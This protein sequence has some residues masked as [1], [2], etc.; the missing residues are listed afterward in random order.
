LGWQGSGQL[1]DRERA[2]NRL[3]EHVRSHLDMA[4]L[5]QIIW[6]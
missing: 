3:A 5:Q 6:G 2:Y 1:F 4:A